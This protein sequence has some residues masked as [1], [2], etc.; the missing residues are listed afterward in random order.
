MRV[1]C[2]LLV[3]GMV[4]VSLAMASIP[5]S[6]AATSDGNN[7]FSEAIDVRNN[8]VIVESLDESDD[9]SDYYKIFLDVGDVV[10]AFLAVP[11]NQDFDLYLYDESYDLLSSSEVDNPGTGQYYEEVN[12]E[13]SSTG[14]Y[15][16][17][18][19]VYSGAGTYVLYVYATA[20]WTLMVYLDGDCD[21]ES[22]ALGDFMEMSEVG[23]TDEVNI[24]VQ[25][26]RHVDYDDS[27]GD[28][29]GCERFM[30][31]QGM[32]PETVNSFESLGE[33]NMGAA[34]TLID[35]GNMAIQWFPADHYALVLW[36]HGGSWT[37]VCW[38]DSELP[39][40]DTLTMPELSSALSTIVSTNGLSSLDVVW[41]DACNMA[42]IEVA[43]ELSGYCANLVGSE[44]TEPGTG[45]NYEMTLSAL[46]GNPYMTSAELCEQIV[47][48]F[49]DSYDSTPETGYIEADVTQSASD[50]SEIPALVASVDGLSS[51]LSANMTQYVNYVSLCWMEA[52]YY[53]EVYIDLHD[54]AWKLVQYLPSGIAKS[55]ASDVMDCVNSTVFAEG[56]W[57]IPGEYE[58]VRAEGLT[59]YF[60]LD[61]YY[62]A[63]YETTGIGFASSTNW[64]E[65][66]NE[67]YAYAYLP[68]SPPS[69]ATSSPVGDQ[70]IVEGQTQAFSVEAS[71]PDGNA[72]SYSWYLDGVLMAED[73]VS[74]E[75][76]PGL[77]DAGPHTIDVEIW[78]GD[79]TDSHAWSVEV[80]EADIVEPSSSVVPSTEYWVVGAPLSVTAE[81]SD[82]SG[83]VVSVSLS[84]RYSLDNSTWS[85]W[86]VF[87]VDMASPWAWSFDFSE[88][89]GYY[90]F[91]SMATDDSGNEEG[92]P[93]MGDATCAFD[94]SP[95]VASFTV[96]PIVGDLSASFEV[97]AST[98]SDLKDPLDVLEVR[99]DWE[100]D[101]VWDTEWTSQKNASHLF[102]APGDY[103][104]RL[105]IR[106]GNGM[107]N[108]T[109]MTV[110]VVTAI[111]EFGAAPVV[112]L[113]LILIMFTA[114][115]VKR[116]ED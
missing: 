57:D 88:D 81:A 108:T 44:K 56:H 114:R 15:Y 106:D 31:T 55:H 72:I 10:D 13:A 8:D 94:G 59:I 71:D 87:G 40:I 64:D 26:D 32:T 89:N 92:A 60:P 24:V 19:Y 79:L 37:G 9:S 17:E 34:Q 12:V 4:L 16:I 51:E 95:P 52:E 61:T 113:G 111:P 6:V 39:T 69:I 76:T 45:A 104:I 50:M 83:L 84:Y 46:T 27:Y 48:D 7:S 36:D 20:E 21:L 11:T 102:G 65:F 18:V 5:S 99:W 73:T 35:F 109:I 68:N 28:W 90:E 66:L 91:Y 115:R 77:G 82:D 96:Y 85:A 1:W 63:E 14:W 70:T 2:T 80:I 43:Y 107:T 101:G 100:D 33:V 29:T 49:I 62:N 74:V 54:L 22:D 98:S 67:F 75:Y 47:S 53:D 110:H 58:I 25:F 93:A 116:T 3:F 86:T 42:S 105:E 41:L 23:S 30:V 38:D 112:V 103:V 78:D 97:N